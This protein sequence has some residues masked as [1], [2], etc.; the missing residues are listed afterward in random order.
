MEEKR[1]TPS[2]EKKRLQNPTNQLIMIEKQDKIAF[3][4]I[5]K[6]SLPKK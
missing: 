3:H 4:S 1:G 5:S 2:L 6:E